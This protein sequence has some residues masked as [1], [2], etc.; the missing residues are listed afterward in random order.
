MRR[1]AERGHHVEVLTSDHRHPD[2]ADSDPAPLAAVHRDLRL[3]FRDGGLWSPS[4][5][6]RLRVE[7]HNQ[8]VLRA[9]LRASRPDVV[10]V[11][12]VGAMS[13]GI[14]TTLIREGIP[15]VYAVSDDWPAYVRQLDP[16]AR[17]VARL[18]APPRLL[19]AV[20]RV[21]A[22]VPD[23]DGSGAFCF[24]SEVTRERSRRSSP[25]T[26]PTST[27]VYS[28]ID[29]RLFA[30]G[31]SAVEETGAVA[32]PLRL[33]YVGRVDPRKG[34]RTAVRALTSLPGATLVVDGRST[35][36]DRATL[37]AWAAEAG[38]ADRVTI[39]CS[40]RADLPGTYRAADVCLFT[41][42][43]EEP[44]GLVPLEAM[45]CGIPVVAS[46][47]GGSGEFL[48]DGAN[49][50]LFEPGDPRSLAAA[51]QR[52]VDDPTL[53]RHL[54]ANGRVSAEHFDVDHLTDAFEAWHT[55]A[56]SGQRDEVPADRQPP[57][58]TPHQS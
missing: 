41:S 2:T 49:C 54:T 21:P 39:Q 14:L 40:E 31:A 26:F 57:R 20:A 8:R 22:A 37:E 4:L 58:L 44:F 23:L 30:S 47:V 9:A 3:Y 35:P 52:I 7:R 45:A 19:E 28:G 15:L 25:W 56:A 55:A 42:E 12:H 48:V 53:V 24:I 16:W 17:A 18:P 27:L 10:S 43:W 1:L 50:V 38:V 13:L 29:G 32:E 6:G 46:G 36:E 34:I 5:V 51:V 11:W 33:L